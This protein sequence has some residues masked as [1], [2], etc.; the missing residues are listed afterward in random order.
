[1]KVLDL[2]QKAYGLSE[3]ERVESAKEIWRIWAEEA[4]SIGTVGLSPAIMGVRIVKNTMGNVPSRQMNA[5]GCR[6][7]G[8]THP[9]TLFF[10]T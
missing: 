3:A 2:F 4:Y 1:V 5:I 7:P 9:A 6:T 8:T 10:K